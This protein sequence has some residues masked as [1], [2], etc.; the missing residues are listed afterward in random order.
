LIC[1]C[2]R[3]YGWVWWWQ[4]RG[5]SIRIDLLI[6]EVDDNQLVGI[7]N[8]CQLWLF[9]IVLNIVMNVNSDSHNFGSICWVKRPKMISSSESWIAVKY[10]YFKLSWTFW[11]MLILKAMNSDIFVYSR[12]GR[13]PTCENCRWLWI[14]IRSDYIGDV[15]LRNRGQWWIRIDFLT[16]EADDNELARKFRFVDLWLFQIVPMCLMNVNSHRNYFRS[17]CWFKKGKTISWWELS[18]VMNCDYLKLCG[19][20]WWIQIQMG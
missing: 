20:V 5:Q 4:M 17:N 7:L 14:V 12:R 13:Q 2:L 11:S 3:L 9:Q 6:S 8:C 15:D 18:I 10:D 16:E 1:D 19:W